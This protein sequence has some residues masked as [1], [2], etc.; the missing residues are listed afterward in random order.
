MTQRAREGLHLW[1]ILI[2]FFFKPFII[3]RIR[4]KSVFGVQPFLNCRWVRYLIVSHRQTGHGGIKTWKCQQP[5]LIGGPTGNRSWESSSTANQ[6]VFWTCGYLLAPEE[7]WFVFGGRRHLKKHQHL[8]L[9]RRWRCVRLLGRVTLARRGAG[10]ALGEQ[11][12][13]AQ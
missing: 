3:Y 2:Y 12:S 9:I 13:G 5:I 4:C 8:W 1:N 6:I 11:M 7:R 10:R